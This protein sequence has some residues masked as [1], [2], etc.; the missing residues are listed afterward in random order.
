MSKGKIGVILSPA[1]REKAQPILDALRSK[2]FES[3]EYAAPQKVRA[4]LLFLSA[5]FAED[6][7]AQ[8]RFFALDSEGR[9]VIPVDLDGAAQPELVK[10]A[11]IARNVTSAQGRT[12]EEIAERVIGG[13]TSL[14][15]SPIWIRLR[16][17]IM[18]AAALLILG[19]GLWF[20]RA[21][22][23]DKPEAD[24]EAALA[25]AEQRYGLSAE[26]LADIAYVYLV[27]DKLY[28]FT[29]EEIMDAEWDFFTWNME[30]DGMQY[31]STVDGHRLTRASY[32]AADL[33]IL[34]LMPKLAG[35][36]FF[37]IDA[38]ALPD[39][40][41]LQELEHVVMADCGFT[42]LSGLA[43]S[44]LSYFASYRCPIGDYSALSECEQL[45][46]VSMEFDFL[47][48]ADLSSF[49]P[50]AL[51]WASFG[52][53][54]GSAEL[55]LS[56]LRN[57]TALEELTIRDIPCADP[58]VNHSMLTDLAF[59]EGLPNLRS[60]T[61][62]R[63][64]NLA[65]V[66]ALG[67]LPALEKLSISD[68]ERL[69]D[70]SALQKLGALRELTIESCP[71]IRDFSPI[72]GC[73]A[74]EYFYI[75]GC[76]QFSDASFLASLPRL[77]E[78]S[79]FDVTLPNLDFLNALPADREM[80]VAFSGPIRDYTALGHFQRYDWL[81]VNP[82]NGLVAPV[83]AALQGVT[84]RNLHLHE[85]RGLDLA[86]LPQVTENLDIWYSDL[87]DL[88]A[89]PSLEIERLTLNDLPYLTSLD[90]IGNL[91]A[92]SK[93]KS[94]DGLILV[95]TGCP[96][97][98]DWSA[99]EG[100]ALENL[101]LEHVYSLPALES[102]D[103]A[104]LKLEG[105]D[106]LTD[107]HFLDNRPENWHYYEIGLTDTENVRDL[108]PLRR[109]KGEKLTVPPQLREQAEELAALGAVGE[110]EIA[111]PEGGWQSYDGDQILLS[112]DELD[113]LP[114]A[115]LRCVRRLCLAGDASVDPER[116][117]VRYGQDEEGRG[118]IALVDTY[119][120]EET[121]VE[122]G[123]LTALPDLAALS[124]LRVLRIYCQ[125]LRDLEGVQRLSSLEEL[126]IGSCDELRDVSALFTL[127]GLRCVQ[128]NGCPV[129]SLQ[130]VQNLTELEELNIADTA[131][132]DLTLLLELPELRRVE[133]SGDMTN[134]IASLEGADL[135]F[136]LIID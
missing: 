51:E 108:S 54:P 50:P 82:N 66:S 71:N 1:D 59:L 76:Y 40:S 33:E 128:I 29:A 100:N 6:E 49:S 119:T 41:G 115:L 83:L 28:H 117:D 84:V 13:L 129:A 70:I 24:D 72:G 53:A 73:A 135:P 91:P 93:Q 85:C 52:Y 114:Q 19:G 95:V 79:L 122:P 57:C 26:D 88:S 23:A 101:E 2:G 132:E 36:D 112:L 61:L 78:I 110:Y 89:M 107:L 68:C 48:K 125:K 69:A 11:L 12:A 5:A 130:G 37:L 62:Q 21:N 86:A 136:E 20:W 9:T 102:I 3:V 81:H 105:V 60:L 45:T 92:F 67:T 63:L 131:V 35:A 116:F 31:Y 17:W 27:S 113:T 80:S 47:E 121:P 46:E 25:V 74:L 18:I 98:T 56:G 4:V 134:A 133:I 104:T 123:A 16:L 10:A 43:G 38:E 15:G 8:E 65:D 32:S 99:L 126:R 94:G 14:S 97:L 42:D 124:E 90:G 106:A 75:W 127:Q 34:R 30:E 7:T 22:T 55:D 111:Y 39:M 96:R 109:L 118:L 77:R 87:R 44:T 120:D 103:F 64:S 58:S